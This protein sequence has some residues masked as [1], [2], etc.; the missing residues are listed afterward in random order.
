M[1]CLRGGVSELGTE[2]ALCCYHEVC[3]PHLG[4]V[5]EVAF[6]R[7]AGKPFGYLILRESAVTE[8]VLEGNVAASMGKGP[9]VGQ[10][11]FVEWSRC[12]RGPACRARIAL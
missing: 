8:D 6:H 2:V 1:R 7:A 3:D 5:W 12:A 11:A 10:D 9:Q 4:G